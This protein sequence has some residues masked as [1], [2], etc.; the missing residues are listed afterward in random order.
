MIDA[1]PATIDR[2]ATAVTNTTTNRN[3]ETVTV[4]ATVGGNARATTMERRRKRGRGKGTTMTK[5]DART[6]IDATT[7]SIAK[8]LKCITSIV[9]TQVA[10]ATRSLTWM[11]TTHRSRW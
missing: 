4:E 3:A 1:A 7:M 6:A 5:I 10:M 9:A 2:D 11:A 8:K